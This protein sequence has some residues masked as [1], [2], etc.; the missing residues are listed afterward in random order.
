MNDS[1]PSGCVGIDTVV[2]TLFG[3]AFA[4]VGYF[5]SVLVENYSLLLKD[6]SYINSAFINKI[7]SNPSSFILDVI[8]GAISGAL[9]TTNKKKILNVIVTFVDS[10]RNSRKNGETITGTVVN[11]IIDFILASLIDT[12]QSFSKFN[13]K[14]IRNSSKKIITKLRSVSKD[15]LK[16]VAK[17]IYNQIIY[18]L[19]HNYKL[20]DR[21]I[22]K[23]ALS[24]A[25][26]WISGEFKQRV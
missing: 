24:S 10:I 4:V 26:N 20:Y 21:Y 11:L 1:D 17:I 23:Y 12:S 9:S 13:F 22:K 7:K 18:Y 15:K 5:L 3:V 8:F 2:G 14:K 16:S 6:I 19:K 25:I